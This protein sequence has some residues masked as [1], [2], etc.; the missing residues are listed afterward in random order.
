MLKL[1]MQQDEY[2]QEIINNSKNTNEITK[3]YTKFKYIQYN[4][5]V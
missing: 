1:F 3:E 4:A 5:I 2:A